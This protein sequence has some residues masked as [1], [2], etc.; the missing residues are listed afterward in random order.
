MCSM[1]WRRPGS[2]L[3]TCNIAA[4]QRVDAQDAVKYG[5]DGA[6]VVRLT[7]SK[8]AA[9]ERRAA[10][11]FQCNTALATIA[12]GETTVGYK[13]QTRRFGDVE[14]AFYIGISGMPTRSAMP[15]SSLLPMYSAG[16]YLSG[17]FNSL[18][19]RSNRKTAAS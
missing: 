19:K 17:M 16:L 3:V 5:G 6:G 4:G 1:P 15:V 2:D 10:P 14:E 12:Y 8:D 9:V 13:R 7:G 18:N 11:E